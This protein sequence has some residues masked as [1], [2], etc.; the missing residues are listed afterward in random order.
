MKV[1]ELWCPG[2]EHYDT[3]DFQIYHK[4]ILISSSGTYYTY[5]N[6]HFFNYLI[7]TSAHNCLT[8]RDPEVKIAGEHI[9]Y[10]SGT[11]QLIND[12]GTRMPEP[13]TDYSLEPD[14]AAA[15]QR[16]MRMARVLSHLES[17]E[18]VELEG[19]L[20]EAYS[21]TCDSVVRKMSFRPGAGECGI[22]TVCDKVTAKSENYIKCF[23]LHTMTEPRIEGNE[24]KIEHNGGRLLVRVIE[25]QNAEITAIG[26]GDMRFTLNGEP[27]PSEKTDNRECGWGKVIISPA[28][29][30]KTHTFKVEMEI[31][32]AEL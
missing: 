3:G 18:L 26:G 14:L 29:N 15:W 12:G 16:D 9:M 31:M 10:P 32:D 25:P 8:V 11:C 21:H 24:I 13:T 22:F 7:R 27:V 4:G 23:H 1:G 30:A 28:D 2:H 17:D 5:G 20:T 19:D 6:N